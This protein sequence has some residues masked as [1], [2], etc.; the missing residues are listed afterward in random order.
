MRKSAYKILLN[1]VQYSKFQ[2]MYALKKKRTFISADI[3]FLHR[4][5]NVIFWMLNKYSL[6]IAK[7]LKNKNCKIIIIACNSASSV[8]FNYI[9][10]NISS[11][12]IFNVIEPIINQ[13]FK[14]PISQWI[15]ESTCEPI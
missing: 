8:A 7:F 5:M 6:Q 4:G 9:Q 11:I 15:G 2:K 14:P 10:N 12:P 13:S 3:Y 1:F